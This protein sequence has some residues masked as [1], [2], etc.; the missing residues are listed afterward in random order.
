M[1]R[2]GQGPDHRDNTL[3]IWCCM[4]SR[5][6]CVNGILKHVSMHS[7]I[8][9]TVWF[10]WHEHTW[11]N[12]SKREFLSTAFLTFFWAS[13]LSRVQG[14][15][16]FPWTAA[17]AFWI[18]CVM[19]RPPGGNVSKVTWRTVMV[20]VMGSWQG[21]I[22]LSEWLESIRGPEGLWCC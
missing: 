19:W 21:Q 9:S 10:V 12:K 1:C 4:F 18:A 16:L 17:W 7:E 13:T 15:V 11:P 20:M 6:L 2:S 22:V 5:V 3:I 8:N 14:K